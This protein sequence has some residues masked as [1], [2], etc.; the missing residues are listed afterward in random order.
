MIQSVKKSPTKRNSKGNFHRN[1]PN[2][3][4]PNRKKTTKNPWEKTPLPT[5]KTTTPLVGHLDGERSARNGTP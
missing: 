5:F 1:H 4:P 2:S 3:P